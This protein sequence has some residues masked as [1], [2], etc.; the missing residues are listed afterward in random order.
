PRLSSDLSSPKR[1]R[2]K[3]YEVSPPSLALRAGG[4]SKIRL[5]ECL[6]ALGRTKC[7]PDVD[8]DRVLDE[9][10]GSVAA[11]GVDAQRV[12]AAG[13][14]HPRPGVRTNGRARCASEF[15]V[16]GTAHQDVGFVG[17]GYA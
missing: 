1:E 9:A 15:R 14:H 7:P 4:N 6:A 10:D 3:A 17:V 13:G 2:G 12:A 5:A 8:V 16:A 11:N